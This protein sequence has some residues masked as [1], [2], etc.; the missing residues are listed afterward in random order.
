MQLS[1]LILG[2]LIFS[3]ILKELNPKEQTGFLRDVTI[4]KLTWSGS[5][6]YVATALI[7]QCATP[8]TIPITGC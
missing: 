6:I 5:Q 7:V 2:T 4:L 1:A 3:S 8:L